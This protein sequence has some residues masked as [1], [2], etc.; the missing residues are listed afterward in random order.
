M[1]TLLTLTLSG[2]ALALLLLLL[3]RVF[4]RQMPSTVYYYAWLLVLLRFALPLP[5]LV[6][7]L[8]PS[9]QP[10]PT[11]AAVSAPC[12]ARA[13]LG[14]PVGAYLRFTR[15]CGGRCAGRTASPRRSTPRSPG[16][17][18]LCTS[19]RGVRTPLMYGVLS[20]K[21]VLPAREYDGELLVNILRHE[22]THYR[23]FDTLYKWL[24]AAVL[25][26]HWFNPLSW[27][28]RRELN[29]ACELSCDEML[30]RR[31]TR[32][33]KQS[34]GNTLLSMAASSALPAGV[35]ATTFATEKRDLKERLEQIMHYKKNGARL[36]AAVLAVAIL[37]G[38]GVAAGPKASESSA[39]ETPETRRR[40]PRHECGRAAR[41][42]RA[43]HRH[44]AAP[45]GVRSQHRLDYGEDTHSAY[46]SW[47]GV[48]GEKGRTAEL[49]ITAW[50]A[51]P[52]AERG[53]TRP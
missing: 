35:V 52:S 4:V 2:S 5:G 34:Y 13:R 7:A 14:A 21:I 8:S 48:W 19:A 20:P 28:I 22:L 29:R 42:H 24:A 40:R 50:T 10:E 38:C 36:L 30:L 12:P 11:P 25:S 45:R 53:R 9:S 41:R 33:E 32:G 44:R 26:A 3:R 37:A 15:G 23:R 43:E 49:V 27:L 1:E 18:P 6:P 39:P 16:A 47:N 31:M 17:S 46:Y 51:S